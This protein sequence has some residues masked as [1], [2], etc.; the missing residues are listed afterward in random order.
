MGV[1]CKQGRETDRTRWY[2]N[3]SLYLVTYYARYIVS[4]LTAMSSEPSRSWLH[5]YSRPQYAA[6]ECWNALDRSA[7]VWDVA[8]ASFDVQKDDSYTGRE[9][10]AAM[11]GDLTSADLRRRREA[12]NTDDVTDDLAK[13]PNSRLELHYTVSHYTLVHNSM[14]NNF[15]HFLP[16]DSLIYFQQIRI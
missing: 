5:C 2:I 6:T 15:Q 1:N 8:C 12:V 11:D 14:L 4:H 3:P 7:I 9:A 10:V 13:M 16:S